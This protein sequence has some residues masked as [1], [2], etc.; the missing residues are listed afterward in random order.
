MKLK[1]LILLF[2]LFACCTSY[3]QTVGYTYKALAAKGCNV[4]YGVAKQDS[5]Y[6]IFVTIKSDR[7]V[8]LQQSTMLLKTFDGDVIKL[9]GGLNSTSSTTAGGHVTGNVVTTSTE[10]CSMAQFET[11][12]EQFELIKN[13]IAKVRLSTIPIEHERAFSKDKIGKKLYQFYLKQRDKDDS[14]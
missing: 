10:I 12:P 4:R 7:I 9:Y 14:F 3:A 2:A 1:Q 6:Y 5:T 8:F 13:G 11:S